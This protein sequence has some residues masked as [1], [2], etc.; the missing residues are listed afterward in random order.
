MAS[1]NLALT[2][3][4]VWQNLILGQMQEAWPGS[5]DLGSLKATF[6]CGS[7]YG[8]LHYPKAKEVINQALVKYTGGSCKGVGY[9]KVGKVLLEDSNAV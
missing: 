4:G 3:K 7:G 2:S 9:G 5:T 6:H 1:V 8:R